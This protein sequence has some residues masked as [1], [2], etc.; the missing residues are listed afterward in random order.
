MLFLLLFLLL[1]NPA[2]AI[3][4]D[5]FIAE[6]GDD[7]NTGD[8]P[9]QAWRSIE[10]ANHA[11]LHPGDRILLQGGGRFAG[12]LLLSI[13]DSDPAAERRPV[14]VSSYGGGSATIDAGAGPG[15]LVPNAGGVAIVGVRVLGAGSTANGSDGILFRNDR[16]GDRLLA[17]I[18]VEDVEVA[19]F[20]RNGLH[21][22]GANRRSGYQNVRFERVV[23]HDNALAGVLTSAAE[24]GVHRDVVVRFSDAYRNPGVPGLKTNSGNGIVLGGVAGGTVEHSRAWENGALCDFED[25]G[26]GIWTYSSDHI[27]I[28]FNESFANR[29]GGPSDGDGFDLDGG[30]TNSV[31]RYNYSHDND[32]AGYLLAQFWGASAFHGNAVYH[33]V[34]IGDGRK[35]HYGGI[36]VWSTV[37]DTDI[38]DNAVYVAASPRGGQ[39]STVGFR[40]WDGAGI[41]VRDNLLVVEGEVP[42]FEIGGREVG[43]AGRIDDNVYETVPAGAA[44]ERG[45]RLRLIDEIWHARRGADLVNVGSDAGPRR[46][47]TVVAGGRENG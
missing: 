43:K 3:A 21:L 42:F 1:L 4:A 27:V 40:D 19:G 7:T 38:H 5:H 9:A 6:G 30:V 2:A 34:S 23:A 39:P 24:P 45:A 46:D 22:E 37:A 36:Q 17:G 28:Q 33:N 16:P 31:M 29:T 18:V 25:G 12:P 47:E 44:S 14:T 13:A 26:A 35:N 20:G 11:V 8:S 15:I 32:G 10:R 41:V